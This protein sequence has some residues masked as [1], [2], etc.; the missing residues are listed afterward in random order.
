MVAHVLMGIETKKFSRTLE[1]HGN[2]VIDIQQSCDF[3]AEV[4]CVQLMLLAS[5][6]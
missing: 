3:V 5:I 2:T 6:G 4:A 1:S